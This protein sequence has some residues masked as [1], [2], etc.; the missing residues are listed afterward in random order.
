MNANL[1]EEQCNDENGLLCI[2]LN[3][4]TK[5]LFQARIL[6]TN[7]II[8]NQINPLKISC[9]DKIEQ[10]KLCFQ[11]KLHGLFDIIFRYIN[12]YKNLDTCTAIIKY[13]L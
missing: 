9:R 5:K 4:I 11:L 7:L 3:A 12:A 2:E 6:T 8:R 1:R 10:L 13:I